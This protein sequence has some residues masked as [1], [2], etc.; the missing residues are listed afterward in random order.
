LAFRESLGG[1]F[2]AG[3][4]DLPFK[5]QTRKKGWQ[6]AENAAIFVHASAPTSSGKVL[7]QLYCTLVGAFLKFILDKSD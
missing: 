4:L 3:R 5:L 2:C 7:R 1:I 6:L